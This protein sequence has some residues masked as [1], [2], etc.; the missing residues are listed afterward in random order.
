MKYL[1]WK[2]QLAAT[3]VSLG[4]LSPAAAQCTLDNNLVDNPS[5]ET[6]DAGDIG[7][8]DSV[9]ISSGLGRHLR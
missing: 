5:F 8:F 6:V 3:L 1:N 4:M 2:R 9:R 7:P